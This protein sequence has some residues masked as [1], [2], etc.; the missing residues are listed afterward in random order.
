MCSLC[1]SYLCYCVL[2]GGGESGVELVFLMLGI[3]PRFGCAK[4]IPTT[5]LYPIPYIHFLFI[6]YW[7]FTPN[8]LFLNPWQTSSSEIYLC[9]PSA[10]IKDA[11][12]AW[13]HF[14]LH[15]R[16]ATSLEEPLNQTPVVTLSSRGLSSIDGINTSVLA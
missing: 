5:Q 7:M 9:L 6:S 14:C 12:V 16:L 11:C 2:V 3:E 4:H 10:G 8:F 13:P 1:V 15:L